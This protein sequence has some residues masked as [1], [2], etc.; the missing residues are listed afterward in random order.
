M[1]TEVVSNKSFRETI[2]EGLRLKDLGQ[3]EAADDL[4]TKAIA[5]REQTPTHNDLSVLSF[6]AT[7][8]NAN[9]R[10]DSMRLLNLTIERLCELAKCLLMQ[11]ILDG[12]GG[13]KKKSEDAIQLLEQS[14]EFTGALITVKTPIYSPF[15]DFFPSLPP[16]LNDMTTPRASIERLYN[17]ASI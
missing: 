2:T 5:W 6:E 1:L 15:S 3:Y 8:P 17:E 9:F 10:R 14:L 12:G 11:H 7:V 4:L 16:K 13:L